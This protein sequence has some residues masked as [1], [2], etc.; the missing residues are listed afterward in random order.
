MPECEKAL[1]KVYEF[2][3]G[4]FVKVERR[5]EEGEPNPKPKSFKRLTSLTPLPPLF[6]THRKIT[7]L[8]HNPLHPP[9]TLQSVEHRLVVHYDHLSLEKPK[10]RYRDDVRYQSR[11]TL[12]ITK[13]T[14]FDQCIGWPISEFQTSLAYRRTAHG[15]RTPMR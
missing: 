5:G 6:Q 4:S 11:S 10:G 3:R 1:K 15:T 7:H 9:S 8:Y 2:L 14:R 13:Q 12:R